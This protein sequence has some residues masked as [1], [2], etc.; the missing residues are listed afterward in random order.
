MR[1]CATVAE[2]LKMLDLY[3]YMM[4]AGQLLFGDRSGDSFILE[5]GHVI[6]RKAGRH[7]VMTNFM[8]SRDPGKKAMDRRYVL[9]NGRLERE[10]SISLELT[11]SLLRAARQPNT[12]YSLIF[13]LTHGAVL[14]YRDRRS[15]RFVELNVQ[16]EVAKAPYAI[17][18]RDLPSRPSSRGNSLTKAS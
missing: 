4:P 13:D 11:T 18:I 7:Q 8:Q 9:V 17:R 2:A 14:I 3:D 6:I 10:S 15:D 16:T 5:A 12:Q 1:K